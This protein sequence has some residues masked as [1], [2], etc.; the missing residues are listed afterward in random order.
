VQKTGGFAG[1]ID[2]GS[3]SKCFSMSTVSNTGTALTGGYAGGF[4]GDALNATIADSYAQGNVTL[5]AGPYGGGFAGR[6]QG[7]SITRSYSRNSVSGSAASR[8][9]FIGTVQ[10]LIAAPTFTSLFYSSAT[11]SGLQDVGEGP[12]LN[13]TEISAVTD[14]A[15]QT[16]STFT[17]WDFVNVWIISGAG[18]YPTL[19]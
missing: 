12:N 8:G 15:L 1:V 16:Q 11:T 7:G 4:V 18:A 2:G 5:A 14:A 6:V 9:G 3:A 19:R 13:P 10:V 17:G